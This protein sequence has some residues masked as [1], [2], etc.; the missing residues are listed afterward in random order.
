MLIECKDGSTFEMF[1]YKCSKC[2]KHAGI[3][4]LEDPIPCDRLCL[5]CI[6][7]LDK[8]EYTDY[9]NKIRKINLNHRQS[10]D[11]M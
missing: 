2:G 6:D 8:D 10:I 11:E 1:C 4:L 5:N 3:S 7:S 9:A